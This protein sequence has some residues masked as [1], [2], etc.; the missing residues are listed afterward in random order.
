MSRLR[1]IR[2]SLVLAA[3]VFISAWFGAG[4]DWGP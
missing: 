2:P 3:A 4:K 1:L